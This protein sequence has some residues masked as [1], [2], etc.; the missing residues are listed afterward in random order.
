M[1]IETRLEEFPTDPAQRMDRILAAYNIAPKSTTQLLLTESQIDGAALDDALKRVLSGS[2]MANS[3]LSA[4]YCKDTL[5]PIGLVARAISLNYWGSEKVVGFTTSSAGE[6]YGK[7]IA[8]LCLDFEYRSG[9]SLFPLLGQTASIGPRVPM[10][11]AAILKLL[12]TDSKPQSEILDELE[13]DNNVTSSLVALDAAGAIEY[14]SIKSSTGKVQVGY[15]IGQIPRDQLQPVRTNRA[16]TSEIADICYWLAEDGLPIT[17][18]S[19][20]KLLIQV[21]TTKLNE[22]NLPDEVSRILSG[23]A[24]QGI[25]K[26]GIYE[27]RKVYSN[28]K[29]TDHGRKIVDELI[30]PMEEALS[31]GGALGILRERVLPKVL[32]TLPEYARITADFYYPYSKLYA[33]QIAGERRDLCLLAINESVKDGITNEDLSSIVGVK[34]STIEHRYVNPLLKKGHIR[35]KGIKGVKYY[36]PV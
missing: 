14:N 25:L 32:A 23:L 4:D 17:Q 6:R 35:V 29:I 3:N 15:T 33:R 5:C 36:F 2:K 24:N 8:A 30:F 22:K 16:L 26:R 19:V 18:A 21:S 11:R 13:R 9:I 27:G 12:Y 34:A 31:D 28:A 7:P 20:S 10:Q 1:K